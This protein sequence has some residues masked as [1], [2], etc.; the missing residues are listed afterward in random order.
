MD[1]AGSELLQQSHVL[2]G[3]ITLVTVESV[4]RKTTMHPL[5]QAISGNLG[6]DG[7]G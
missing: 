2:G 7:G 5:H 6:Q 1:F 3:W 4:F